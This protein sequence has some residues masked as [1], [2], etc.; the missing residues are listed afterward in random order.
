MIRVDVEEY[1]HAC[2]D[3]SP[4]VTKAVKY[5]AYDGEILMSDT[6]IH[7]ENRR[8]CESIRKYLVRQMAEEEAVG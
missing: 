5:Q 4:D 3:F 2:M 7:C 8:R 1:C 6:V